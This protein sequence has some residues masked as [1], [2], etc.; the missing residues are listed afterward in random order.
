MSARRSWSDRNFHSLAPRAQ[1]LGLAIGKLRG[2]VNPGYYQ[3]V[4]EAGEQFKMLA[5]EI[6]KKMNFK[7]SN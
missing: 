2:H 6:L 4:D 5:R 7:I 1:E 3:Q